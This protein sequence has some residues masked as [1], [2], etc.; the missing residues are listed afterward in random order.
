[1]AKRSRNEPPPEESRASLL[2]KHPWIR[3]R[4]LPM[5]V[6]TDLDALMSALF[7]HHSRGWRIVGFYN[8]ESVFAVESETLDSLRRAVWVD[9]D[10]AQADIR[11]IGHHIVTQNRDQVPPVLASSLNPNLHRRISAG[12]FAR[13]YPLATVHWLAWLLDQRIDC[14][15]A[16]QRSLLWLPDS[17]WIVAQK[18]RKN[19]DDWL[20]NFMPHALLLETVAEC[21]TRG[22]EAAMAKL[23]AR[24]APLEGFRQQKRGQIKSRHLGLQGF[25]FRIEDPAA[26]HPQIQAALRELGAIMGWKAP[27]LSPMRELIRG[28]TNPHKTDLARFLERE[29]VFS[30]AIRNAEVVVYT[31]IPELYR[32]P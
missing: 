19:V 21:E 15:D 25:Q 14:G 17:A 5:V 6:G 20:G 32:A 9:L 30:Y 12:Q 3:E 2:A 26:E 27:T 28:T 11:S 1:M 22:F 4:D 10:I 16:L 18:Y 29:R 7:L 13:K 31:S 24:L 8:L 23:F